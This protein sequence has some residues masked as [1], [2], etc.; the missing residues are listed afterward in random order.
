MPPRYAAAR[1]SAALLPQVRS[2]LAWLVSTEL[3]RVERLSLQNEATR[4]ARAW[5]ADFMELVAREV[6]V[7]D[8]IID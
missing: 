2:E 3:P 5:Q 7:Y 1:R 8:V 6:M 4:L